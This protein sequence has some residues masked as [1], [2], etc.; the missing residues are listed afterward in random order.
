MFISYIIPPFESEA[1]LVRCIESL[2]GQTADDFEVI[3]AESS[4][5][6]CEDYISDALKTKKNFRIIEECRPEE[7][8]AAAVRMISA[9]A[10]FVQ[11]VETST[12]VVPHA[13]ETI[14]SAAGDAQLVM[15]ASI[16]RRSD[17][18]VKRFAQ[19][20]E[21]A[22][23]MGAMN[24]F[25][26]CFRK[27][28]FERYED[29][30]T[31]D[32]YDVETLIDMLIG[33]GISFVFVED[34]CCYM[35]KSSFERPV[36][37]VNDYD[38][39]QVISAGIAKEEL[40]S[41]KVKLFTKYIHRLTAVLDS[42]TAELAEKQNAYALLK[43]FGEDAAENNTLSK[44]FVLNT[45]IP[46]SDMNRLD[47]EGYRTLRSE[48]F[49]L[50]DT[51]TSVGL[52]A[53][54]LDNYNVK[55]SEDASRMERWIKNYDNERKEMQAENEKMRNDIAALTA[56]MHLLMERI[57]QGGIG[58][59]APSNVSSFTNPIEEVPFLF[60]TGRLGMKAIFKC[61]SGWFRFKFSKKK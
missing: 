21:A 41:A 27:S 47:L 51:E 59:A 43:Q 34:V 13:L 25:D 40:G 16:L 37:A 44:I 26:Y 3:V 17:G 15:P 22:D 29:K 14:R 4:F 12:V 55:R 24:A 36:I 8:L 58:T 54:L 49:R 7:K 11:F 18:F 45:G 57:E 35:T 6:T 23:N 19:G 1:Y 33:S 5:S 42:Q 10:E 52:I 2:Y 9:D 56:N 28:L 20:W 61:I 48:Q 53:D 31:A 60:A 38:M 46:V 30:I 50:A 32:L 39:L